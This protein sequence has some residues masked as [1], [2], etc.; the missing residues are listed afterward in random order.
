LYLA[1]LGIVFD[2]N[3]CKTVTSGVFDN[4]T[5][6][7]K[8]LEKTAT[9][10]VILIDFDDRLA[11]YVKDTPSEIITIQHQFIPKLEADSISDLPKLQNL[12]LA[13]NGIREIRKGAFRNL[14]NLKVLN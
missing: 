2:F 7:V 13:R 14:P 8:G 9:E 12:I 10:N 5:V 4:V 3:E 11:K 6:L 1:L